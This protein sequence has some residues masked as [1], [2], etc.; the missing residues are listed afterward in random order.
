MS[1][2]ASLPRKTRTSSPGSRSK[3][4][5]PNWMCGA[6]QLWAHGSLC[7]Q[8][9]G[10]VGRS[11]AHPASRTMAPWSSPRRGKPKLFKPKDESAYHQYNGL[12]V[13]DLRRSAIRNLVNAGAFQ[14]ELLG[15]LQAAK[16]ERCFTLTTSF[17]RR[18]DRSHGTS[19]NSRTAA[20][21]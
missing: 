2:N 16:R 1:R 5:L 9:G 7:L 11:G 20:T 8:T 4:A 21:P 14:G 18:R 6:Q 10:P 12:I 15:G 17:N 19:G 13:H 3:T